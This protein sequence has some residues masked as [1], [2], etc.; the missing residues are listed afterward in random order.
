MIR[1]FNRSG[2]SQ[3][4]YAR[5]HGISL[6]TLQYWLR[7]SNGKKQSGNPTESPAFI[8]VQITPDQHPG[9]IEIVYPDG[10]TVRIS[11]R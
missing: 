8:P 6:S 3:S 5:R 1:H 9:I 11:L 4:A 2:L 10:P 7:K